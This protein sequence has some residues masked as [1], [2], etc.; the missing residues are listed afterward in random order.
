MRGEFVPVA[1]E[2]STKGMLK[3]VKKSLFPYLPEC[4]IDDRC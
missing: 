3:R 1:K 4:R 2:M